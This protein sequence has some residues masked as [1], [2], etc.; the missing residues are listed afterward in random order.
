VYKLCS[1][2]IQRL[3]HKI[4]SKSQI[5]KDMFSAKR[6]FLGKKQQSLL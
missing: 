5:A 4:T 6:F 3:E 1:L 2:Q